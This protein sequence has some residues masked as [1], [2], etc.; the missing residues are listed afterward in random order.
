MREHASGGAVS[1]AATTKDRPI[2]IL[3]WSL[4]DF[5]NS[6]YATSVMAILFPAM[7]KQYWNPSDVDAT[8]STFRLSLATSGS[9]LAVALL[10]PVLGAIADRGSAKKRFL[11]FFFAVGVT[12]TA[13]LYLIEQGAWL[14]AGFVY[15]A[16]MIGFMGANTFYDALLPGIVSEKKVDLVSGLGFGVGYLGG[17]LLLVVHFTLISDWQSFGFESVAAAS[18][19]CIAS[20]GVWW[21]VFALPLLFFVKEERTS[22]APSEGSVI[23]EGFLQLWRTF[24]EV[25]RLRHT[26]LFLLAYWFYIDGVDTV[27]LMATDYGLSLGFAQEALM[28]AFLVT[29][30]VGFPAAIAFGKLGEKLGPKTGLY[31]GIVAYIGICTY[32]FFLTSESQFLGIAVAVGL[33][34]GGIQALSR[35]LYTR[36][37][38]PE[39]AGE[40]FG[41]YNMLGK[42]AAV[43][44]PLLMG[45]VGVLT[46]ETRYGIL[47][48]IALFVLGGL[49]LSRVDVAAGQ[50]AANAVAKDGI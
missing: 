4:Y 11:T 41:F 7:F 42:F 25:R 38:P 13:A 34:Q 20:V 1:E 47:S 14:A 28:K 12:M 39:R 10:A 26:G 21:A 32:G 18:R 40:F 49:F 35:S 22:A 17:G 8:V 33:V 30:F 23:K 24:H 43:L 15:A 36:L 29:Q 46:G 48:I 31:I 2:P 19:A 45:V 9:G 5:A 16:S 6:A 27:I 50:R 3:S 44:G 37:I